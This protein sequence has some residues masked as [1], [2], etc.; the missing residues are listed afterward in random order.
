MLRSESHI[1]LRCDHPTCGVK[2]TWVEEEVAKDA[3]KLPDGAYRFL[4]LAPLV[5]DKKTFCSKY[6][7]LDAMKTYVPPQSPRE[8][9]VEKEEKDLIAA[10]VEAAAN[11][12]CTC[13]EGDPTK[14]NT[15]CPVHSL[16]FNGE[17]AG[18]GGHD[19]SS[20]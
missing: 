7:L 18:E 19:L 8:M 20:R 14:A 10:K 15:N 1:E 4:I 12:T 3:D 9:R 16:A 13:P 6:C 11:S 2:F 17:V 5:G